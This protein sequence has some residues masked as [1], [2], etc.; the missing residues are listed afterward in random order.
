MDPGLLLI[1]GP[2]PLH[3]RVL[4]ELAKPALPHSGDAWVRAF[5]ET[6]SLMRYLWSA[7]EHRV[8]PLAGPG[9]TGLESLAYTFLRPGDRVAVLSDGFFGDRMREV[10]LTH[11]LKADVV[12]SPWGAGPDLDGLRNA[13][14]RPTK[15]VAVVDNETSTGVANPLGRSVR[16][17]RRGLIARGHSPSGGRDRHRR[18][19]RRIPEMPRGAGR[20]HPGRGRPLALGGD[21]SEGRGRLVPEPLHVG[22]VRPRVGRVA[23]DADDDLLE[24]VLRVPPRAPACQGGRPGGPLRP[25]RESVRSTP[26]RPRGSRVHGARGAGP[27]LEYRHVHVTSRGHRREHAGEAPPPRAQHHDFGRARAASRQDRPHRHDGDAGRAGRRRPAPR[28]GSV[29]RLTCHASGRY[30]VSQSIARSY[31][32]I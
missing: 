29:P 11:R 7:P 24:P 10:L 9:H 14:K 23:P 31:N 4:E 1:P 3:P 25:P 30:R 20:H 28:R 26:R 18:R 13:L 12:A 16:R 15:A 5:T 21:R 2:V 22:T 6:V 19:V 17:R 32:T 8:F 27:R